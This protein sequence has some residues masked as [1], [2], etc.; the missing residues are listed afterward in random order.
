MMVRLLGMIPGPVLFGALIDNTCIV[1][2]KSCFNEGACAFYDY[3]LISRLLVILD[4]II[5]VFNIIRLY[6][7][8]YLSVFNIQKLSIIIVKF[9]ALLPPFYSIKLQYIALEMI[10]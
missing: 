2:Q 1:W 3:F 7:V 9:R 4:I 8:T 6:N 5:L 10:I